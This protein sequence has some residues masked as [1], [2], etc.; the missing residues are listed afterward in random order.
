MT[1]RA[2]RSRKSKIPKRQSAI[3]SRKSKIWKKDRQYN[4]HKIPKGQSEER[5]TI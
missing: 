4:S 1:K 3:R 5:Q 2:I